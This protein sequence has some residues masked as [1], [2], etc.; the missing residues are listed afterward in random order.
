MVDH[1]AQPGAKHQSFEALLE[2]ALRFLANPWKLWESG[3]ITLRRMVLRLAFADRFEYHRIEG[4]RTPQ[5][6]LPFKALRGIS[7]GEF[8][9]GAGGGT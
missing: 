6:A 2:H 3:D 7:G 4:A 9:S 8:V 1:L 5:I